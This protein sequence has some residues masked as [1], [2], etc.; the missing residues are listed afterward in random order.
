MKFCSPEVL[1]VK[2]KL[3]F[4]QGLNQVNPSM[5]SVLCALACSAYV[6]CGAASAF[7]RAVWLALR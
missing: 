2:I 5:D 7:F 1:S 3:V 4:P 6:G